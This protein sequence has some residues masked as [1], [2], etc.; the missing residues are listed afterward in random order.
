MKRKQGVMLMMSALMGISIIGC[1]NNM[2]VENTTSLSESIATSDLETNTSAEKTTEE[3]TTTLMEATSDSTT[4]TYKQDEVVPTEEQQTTV[5]KQEETII[6]EK[7]YTYSDLDK[8]MYVK[9][10]VNVRTLP[11]TD[12]EKIGGLSTGQQVVVT[13]QCNETKWYRIVYKDQIAYVSNSYLVNDK[14]VEETTQSSEQTKD[15]FIEFH[16]NF[17]CAMYGSSN[18]ESGVQRYCVC[19]Y[20][21]HYEVTEEVK[22][23]IGKCTTQKEKEWSEL[24]KGYYREDGF[25]SLICGFATTSM[26]KEEFEESGFK[27][28]A[29][30][31]E[32][33]DAMV[34][35][36]N[37][38]IQQP[39]YQ[40]L[41]EYGYIQII[42][43]DK[44]INNT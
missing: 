44:K 25:I 17:G 14:P 42:P 26:S 28:S 12:G 11:S 31:Y 22:S 33:Y 2:I 9:S 34:K 30:V 39:R 40:I 21:I 23:L 29:L 3:I 6:K 27:E 5:I 13:G 15:K 32:S 16:N 4:T 10:S 1:G 38:F 37:D 19:I 24:I 8:T 7:I 35:A 36:E 20:D 41:M 43:Y 18:C